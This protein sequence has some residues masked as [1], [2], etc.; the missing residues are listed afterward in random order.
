MKPGSIVV[1]KK[2]PPE[3]DFSNVKWLPVDDER[4]PYTLKN[5]IYYN[6]MTFWTFE[7]GYIGTN[8]DGIE[9]GI[10]KSFIREILPPGEIPEEIKEIIEEPVLV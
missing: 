4:T 10:N 7:E 5:P 8:S 3:S 9:L 2:L 6:C 1:V